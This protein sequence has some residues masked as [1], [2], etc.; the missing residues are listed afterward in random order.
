MTTLKKRGYVIP[1]SSLNNE[2]INK[3]KKDLNVTPFVS[4]SFA[5]SKPEPFKIYLES[6]NHYYVP[7][8]YGVKNFGYNEFITLDKG[9]EINVNFKGEPRTKQL[10]VINNFMNECKET[11]NYFDNN[12]G[13][14][15][16]VGCG[17]GKCLGKD[18]PIMM[19]DGTIKMVQDIKVGDKIMGDDSKERNILTLARGRETMYKVIPTKG[20][21]YI[22]NESHILSLK[23]S[24]DRNKNIKKN[25]VVDMSVLEYLNLPKSY[26]DRAGPLLGYRVPIDYP[27]KE[28]EL[29]PYML[30]YWLGDGNSRNSAISTQD[31]TIIHYFVK[32]LPDNLYLKYVSQ[33]DY[34][35]NSVNKNN[36]FQNFLRNNNLIL[37][38]HIPHNYKCNT[39]EIRLKILAGILDADGYYSKGGYD[40]I[41]KSEKLL[42]DIIYIA[43][44]LGFAAYKKKCKKSCMYKGEKR[45]GTYYR[46]NIQGAGDEIPCIIPRKKGE[47]RKQIKDVL[48]TRIRLEKLDIDEYYGFEIDGNRRFVLGDFKVTHN[49]VMALNFITKLKRK[50]LIIV[51]KT[52][53]MNQWRDRILEFIPDASIGYIQGDKIEVEDKD[54]V[55]GM[56]QSISQREY[57]LKIFK[58]FGFT[59][60]DECHHIGAETFSR[61]LFKINSYYMLGLSATPKRKDGLS[62]VFELFLGGYVYK[63]TETKK[64]KTE[65]NLIEYYDDSGYNKEKLMYNGRVN[66]PGMINNICDNID[67]TKLIIKIIQL[68]IQD[69]RTQILILSDRR[70]HLNEINSLILKDKICSVGFY[71]GGMKEKDLKLSETKKVLLGTYS[72]SSEGMDIPSLNTLILASPKSDIEQSIGRIQRK[73]HELTPKIYDIIDN[74]STFGNQKNKRLALYRKFDYDIYKCDLNDLNNKTLIEKKKKGRSPKINKSKLFIMD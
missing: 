2:Q 24:T 9:K 23:Y 18:T 57:D 8:F 34:R 55:I 10:P 36:T 31:S 72:M 25:D 68:C 30:G 54:I 1:K 60:I 39:R 33:Y 74:F 3:I 63:Q 47:K 50:T 48:K 29:D 4:E 12:K 71:V 69:D 32:N 52:F 51:H 37:N 14:I 62:I 5:L 26:H 35:I 13:G 28:V 21:P 45:S 49:T 67:R 19:Y 17:F 22:V 66:V 16:S 59:I 64:V 27:E 38:K 7:K 65:V 61:S 46:T 58:D 41:Q 73:A 15:I 40:I 42:D 20:E 70:N 11:S 6:K 56:L 44:S 43:R 53:L